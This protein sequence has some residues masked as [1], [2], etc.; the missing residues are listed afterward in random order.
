MN[1]LYRKLVD[2]YAAQE[3]TEEMNSELEQAAANDPELAK[4]MATLT[5]TVEVLRSLPGP[6]FDENDYLRIL[7]KM[8]TAGADISFE[9]NDA[10][11][12]QYQL[13]M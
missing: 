12:W 11:P 13:P 1:D 5:Q 9:E 10:Q 3:L 8:Q 2:L 4:D 6:R 7:F